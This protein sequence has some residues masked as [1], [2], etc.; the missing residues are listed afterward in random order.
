MSLRGGWGGGGRTWWPG[1]A[2]FMTT[3]VPSV[4][5]RLIWCGGAIRIAQ[6]NENN[7]NNENNDENEENNSEQ[8]HEDNERER[9]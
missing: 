9:G 7:E 2:L 8:N 5:K 6:N 3:L 4:E 1:T